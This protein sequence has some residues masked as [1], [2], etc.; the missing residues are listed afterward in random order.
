MRFFK[1][2]DFEHG[3]M[4]VEGGGPEGDYGGNGSDELRHRS[5]DA[6][7][8]GKSSLVFRYFAFHPLNSLA[9]L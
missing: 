6:S 1:G 9:K 5:G 8:S 4:E 7:D 3:G 2:L